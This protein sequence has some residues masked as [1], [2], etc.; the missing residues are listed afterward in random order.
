MP[1]DPLPVTDLV[2][3]LDGT[4]PPEVVAK[5]PDDLRA[6]VTDPEFV[7]KAREQIRTARRRDGLLDVGGRREAKLEPIRFLPAKTQGANRKARRRL[8]A[9]LRG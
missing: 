9:A 4:L 7:R 1:T 3:N 6:R 8:Q 5:L 2:F